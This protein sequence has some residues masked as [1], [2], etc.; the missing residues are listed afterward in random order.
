MRQAS[1]A[2]TLWPKLCPCPISWKSEGA[3]AVLLLMGLPALAGPWDNYNPFPKLPYE[4]T[5]VAQDELVEVIEGRRGEDRSDEAKVAACRQL[6]ED[7]AAPVELRRW[8]VFSAVKINIMYL[9]RVPEAI[10][11][12]RA[13]LAEYSEDPEALRLRLVIAQAYSDRRQSPFEPT[14]EEVLAAY[15]EIFKN[16][17]PQDWEVIQAR[18]YLARRLSAI[19][20][21]YPKQERTLMKRRQEEI[22]AATKAVQEKMSTATPEER[23]G[24]RS[25]LRNNI[26]PLLMQRLWAAPAPSRDTI[27]E[28][29][30]GFA[31]ILR[32]QGYPEEAIQEI[33]K[34]LEAADTRE[35]KEKSSPAAAQP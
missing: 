4:A 21:L 11:M 28:G 16:H 35:R 5:T 30:R 14:P 15:D 9:N 13:W 6:A 12:G 8:A 10:S 1:F 31:E 34:Y 17:D 20:S 23:E 33:M 27:E 25:Y 29:R 19:A 24:L 22:A 2:V 18:V 3:G 32:K 7:P 26:D